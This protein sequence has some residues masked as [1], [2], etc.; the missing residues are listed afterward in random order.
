MP[1]NTTT[2]VEYAIAS[3]SDGSI[4][5]VLGTERERAFKIVGMFNSRANRGE[6]DAEHFTVVSRTITTTDWEP[7]NTGVVGPLMRGGVQP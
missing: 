3:D 4:Q 5:M 1:Q 6:Q 7:A 2:R